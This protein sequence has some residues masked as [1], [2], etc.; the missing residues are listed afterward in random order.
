MSKNLKVINS[1]FDVWSNL[2]KAYHEKGEPR[3]MSRLDFLKSIIGYK[4][5]KHGLV[6]LLKRL[7]DAVSDEALKGDEEVLDKYSKLTETFKILGQ[8]IDA[9]GL[10]NNI[11]NLDLYLITAMGFS[12]PSFTQEDILSEYMFSPF[13]ENNINKFYYKVMLEEFDS[14]V[15]FIIS[16]KNGV[17][18][19]YQGVEGPGER[20]RY[21]RKSDVYKYIQDNIVDNEFMESKFNID[22]LTVGSLLAKDGRMPNNYF[23]CARDNIVDGKL[24]GLKK[25][26]FIRKVEYSNFVMEEYKFKEMNIFCI[27]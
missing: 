22:C 17:T 7:N 1:V 15:D 5:G 20:L 9:N 13:D 26:E 25:V 23:V 27:C 6:V 24:F 19:H 12:K 14:L 21:F 8:E 16:D 18:N 2:E 4:N 10:P 11:E 3:G